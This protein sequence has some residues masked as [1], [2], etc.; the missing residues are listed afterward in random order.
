LNWRRCF[1]SLT[2]QILFW[3]RL[4]QHSERFVDFIDLRDT[5]D[6]RLLEQVYGELY[7]ACFMDPDEQEDLEQYRERL[8]DA[9]KPAPQP[10]THFLVAGV[11]LADA[12]SRVLEGMLIFEL[13]RE[14][15]CGLLTYLA[16]APDARGRGLGRALLRRAFD[17][18]THECAESGGLR[19]VFAET[20]DPALIDA[21][22]DAMSPHE[23]IQVM[24]RLGAYRVPIRYVQPELR[25][26]DGRSR[27]L[28]L[29][30][31]PIGPD[32]PPQVSGGAILHFMHEF[33]LALGVADP[34]VDPDYQMMQSDIVAYLTGQ[35]CAGV[36]RAV[37]LP[38][39]SWA[40]LRE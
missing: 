3:I 20:H 30:T 28:L 23:R 35:P 26:G 37:E 25:P 17:A 36:V 29:L 33:Y 31:F 10:V 24:G 15:S 7:L 1:E 4:S 16:V 40:D 19:A 2:H 21:A 13:Y 22:Q 5:R 6:Q 34:L 39:L 9:Q 11:N 14:S 8:F 38:G 12:G 32:R 27:K 18:L